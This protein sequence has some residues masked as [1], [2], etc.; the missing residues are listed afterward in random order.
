[1]SACTIV[2]AHRVLIR[3]PDEYL[4]PLYDA[5]RAGIQSIEANIWSIQQD[6]ISS[7]PAAVL[8]RSSA[9]PIM[10]LAV[11]TTPSLCTRSSRPL[12]RRPPIVPHSQVVQLKLASS[13]AAPTRDVAHNL[14]RNHAERLPT[15]VL[16]AIAAANGASAAFTFLLP[17]MG[18]SLRARSR[19]VA[20]KTGPYSARALA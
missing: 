19:R 4:R 9:M 12:Y 18:W 20:T 14:M 6:N 1:V 17:S 2:C 3:K 16:S 13:E 15:R 8:V 5:I 7:V 11:P 10:F